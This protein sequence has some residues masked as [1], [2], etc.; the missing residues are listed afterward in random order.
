MVLCLQA[1][2][3]RKC[4]QVFQEHG[5]VGGNPN[6][7]EKSISSASEA[8]DTFFAA[9]CGAD[10]SIFGSGDTAVDNTVSKAVDSDISNA[11]TLTQTNGQQQPVTTI[12]TSNDVPRATKS[13]PAPVQ[14]P[15]PAATA[16]PV[17]A[18]APAV[19]AQVPV[20]QANPN[21]NTSS[22]TLSATSKEFVPN[23]SAS[24][25]TSANVQTPN[26]QQNPNIPAASHR[27]RG[28]P[29]QYFP[30]HPQQVQRYQQFLPRGHAGYPPPNQNYYSRSAQ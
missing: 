6:A 7:E 25:N 19:Q 10:S 2:T 1:N 12:S 14:T 29:P 3:L 11:P 21:T 30:P 8:L 18:P 16:A 9:V 15:A 17:P 28:V 13:V 23:F 4:L 24:T 22:T 26:I 5:V 20:P 27:P